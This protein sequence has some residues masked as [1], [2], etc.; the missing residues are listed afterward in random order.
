MGGMHMYAGYGHGGGAQAHA[1]SAYAAALL[2]AQDQHRR[3]V[4]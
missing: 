2:N 4:A 1:A 3:A